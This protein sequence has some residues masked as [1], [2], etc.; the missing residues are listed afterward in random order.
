MDNAGKQLRSGRVLHTI[1]EDNETV[2]NNNT[3]DT[4]ET[5]QPPINMDLMQ[6]M[7]ALLTQNKTLESRFDKQDTQFK[8]LKESQVE[9]TNVILQSVN[10][11]VEEIRVERQQN[12][13]AIETLYNMNSY[14]EEQIHKLD[15]K[16]DNVKDAL[17]NDIQTKHEQLQQ[18]LQTELQDL[19]VKLA[20]TNTNA[21]GSIVVIAN[22]SINNRDIPK[23]KFMLKNPAR[24]LNHLKEYIQ[25]NN[26]TDWP[27]TRNILRISCANTGAWLDLIIDEI[28]TFEQFEQRFL[29]QFWNTEI[30]AEFCNRVRFGKY[31]P[32]GNL[33]KAQYVQQIAN[34]NK[35]LQTPFT[36]YVLIH[37][38]AK[39]FNI[40]IIKAC[41][42]FNIQKLD[43]FIKYLQREDLA[44]KFHPTVRQD[45]KFNLQNRNTTPNNVVNFNRNNDY[46][47]N[48]KP[49]NASF[50][51]QSNFSSNRN[52]TNN[53][54]N[55]N[56]SNNNVSRSNQPQVNRQNNNNFSNRF[57]PNQTNTGRLSNNNNINNRNN[58]N[59]GN[60]N[61]NR[62]FYTNEEIHSDDETYTTNENSGSRRNRRRQSQQVRSMSV[63]RLQ[64]R[65][66]SQSPR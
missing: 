44:E 10:K 2:S 29:D 15:D 30:Q 40:G 11:Q 61:I 6:M 24:F 60:R 34:V 46:Q 58:N 16:V 59:N 18:R 8:N 55:N 63:D 28:H 43:D 42:G 7:Q 41:T 56:F 14:Q 22:Y 51:K 4:T 13:S 66:N 53:N 38:L 20:N 23:F 52:F 47:S 9:Q 19:K 36:E 26:M 35:Y 21:S 65:K 3:P 27:Q 5:T 33:T 12:T 31:I 32:N 64:D 62:I 1:E 48:N 17:I 45:F 25:L 57:N 49:F 54:N 39:H 50:T 37:M